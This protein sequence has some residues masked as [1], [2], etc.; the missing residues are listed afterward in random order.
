MPQ[1]FIVATRYRYWYTY[2]QYE[3]CIH[4]AAVYLGDPEN[5]LF[6]ERV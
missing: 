6:L 1:T 4:F 5:G 3:R 2:I